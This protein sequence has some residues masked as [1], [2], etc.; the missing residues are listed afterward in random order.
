[1]VRSSRGRPLSDGLRNARSCSRTSAQSRDARRRGTRHTAMLK[2]ARTR[3][4]NDFVRHATSPSRRHKARQVVIPKL[5]K[6]DRRRLKQQRTVQPLR[7][8]I[9]P[10]QL[11]SRSRLHFPC[12][13][14]GCFVSLFFK[15]NEAR[16]L[17]LEKFRRRTP[18]PILLWVRTQRSLGK[19]RL[20]RTP[21]PICTSASVLNPRWSQEPWALRTI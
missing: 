17:R 13:Q 4:S 8:S 20:T 3:N 19:R 15:G 18:S 5:F 14:F 21:P 7:H 9:C 1:M 10:P 16:Q 12:R 6:F 11:A 2:L